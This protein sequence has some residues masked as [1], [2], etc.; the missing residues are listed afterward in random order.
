M[1]WNE[2]RQVKQLRHAPIRHHPKW[3]S[4]MRAGHHLPIEE[5]AWEP[6]AADHGQGVSYKRKCG[7]PSPGCQLHEGLWCLSD[8]GL[9]DDTSRL[10]VYESRTLICCFTVNC[11]IMV[12]FFYECLNWSCFVLNCFSD[13]IIL[14]VFEYLWKR[15]PYV[16]RF[17]AKWEFLV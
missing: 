4:G 7:G 12:E 15:N 9:R 6:W 3:R 14:Q 8:L 11:E 5:V 1:R 10:L 13:L 2:Q 17:K 16:N